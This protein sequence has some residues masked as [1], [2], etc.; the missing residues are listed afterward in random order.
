[1]LTKVISA[2][3]HENYFNNGLLSKQLQIIFLLKRHAS[4]GISHVWFVILHLSSNNLIEYEYVI[5]CIQQ[6]IYFFFS[7]VGLLGE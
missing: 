4:L 1:M 2:I 3:L 6:Y 5:L 7:F